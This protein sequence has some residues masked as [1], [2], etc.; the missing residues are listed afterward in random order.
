MKLEI[1]LLWIL[2]YANAFGATEVPSGP[3]VGTIAPDFKVRNLVP[4]PYGTSGAL[5]A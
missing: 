2:L 1:S 3:A 5:I 4:G